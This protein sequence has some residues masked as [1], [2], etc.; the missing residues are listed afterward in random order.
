MVLAG[1]VLIY[2]LYQL[3]WRPLAVSNDRLKLQNS[4]ATASLEAVAQLAAQYRELQKSGAQVQGEGENLT[5]LIDRT[6]AAHTLHMSRF[7]PGSSGDVQVRLDNAPFDNVLRW[8][9]QLET[10]YALTIKDLSIAPGA[11]SGLVNVS[12]RLYRP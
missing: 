1:A 3:A 12:V 9:H 4:A 10:E 2:I 11:G 8:L 6:V 5:Q 7:Q